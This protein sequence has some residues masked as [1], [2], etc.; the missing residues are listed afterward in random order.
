M[1]VKN[2]ITHVLQVEE[3]GAGGREGTRRTGS[4]ESKLHKADRVII[5]TLLLY[6]PVAQSLSVQSNAYNATLQEAGQANLLSWAQRIPAARHYAT[7]K[8][9]STISVPVSV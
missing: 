5:T 8:Q 6:S 4:F 7:C 2:L 9:T 3:V 1:P